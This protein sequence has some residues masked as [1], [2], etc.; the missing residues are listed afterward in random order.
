MGFYR[1]SLIHIVSVLGLKVPNK[2]SILALVGVIIAMFTKVYF[3][4]I[5]V[6]QSTSDYSESVFK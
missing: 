1:S 6:A 4:K 5:P 3:D 2:S